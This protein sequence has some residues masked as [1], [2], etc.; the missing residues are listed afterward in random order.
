MGTQPDDYHITGAIFEPEGTAAG[1][2]FSY[3]NDAFLAF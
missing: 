2:G 1:S 3:S